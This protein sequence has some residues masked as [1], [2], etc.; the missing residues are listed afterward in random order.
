V[1]YYII[2]EGVTNM[3][4]GVAL[5]LCS[6]IYSIL[7][8]GVYFFKKRVNTQE[9]KIYNALLIVNFINLIL[10][11]LCCYTVYNMDKMPFFTEIINRLF[12]IVIFY[13]QTLFTL[14]NYM[15]S[16]KTRTNY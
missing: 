13:W 1:L 2:V 16:F 12:L 11:L 4:V 9:T 6:L 3:F 10:E 15:I 14:Y 7:I 5:I 8:L